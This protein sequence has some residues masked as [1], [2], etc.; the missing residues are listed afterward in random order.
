MVE[1]EALTVDAETAALAR[2]AGLAVRVPR[3]RVV[4]VGSGA[5]NTA[6]APQDHH[7]DV[8]VGGKILEERAHP[9]PHRRVAGV[10]PLGVVERDPRDVGSVV[11]FEPHPFVGLGV[12]HGEAQYVRHIGA[13]PR[14]GKGLRR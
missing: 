8:V 14:V 12:A 10:A 9:S 11:T 6:A 2:P 7:L 1:G 4:H 5:E 13:A 3:V